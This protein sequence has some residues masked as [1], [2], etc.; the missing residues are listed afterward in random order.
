MGENESRIKGNIQ[1]LDHQSERQLEFVQQW[2]P[3]PTHPPP[4]PQP[5]HQVSI[6]RGHILECDWPRLEKPQ[7]SWP[8]SEAGKSLRE[9]D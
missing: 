9:M 8:L 6:F 5:K 7:L 1:P 4:H 2:Q 3:S